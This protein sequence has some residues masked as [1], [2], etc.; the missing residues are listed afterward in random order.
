[1]QRFRKYY[2]LLKEF[3][4]HRFKRKLSEE[5]K[6]GMISWKGHHVEWFGSP[7]T[8]VVIHK[9][10]VKNRDGNTFYPEK[11]AHA[12]ELIKGADGMDKIEFLTSYGFPETIS[13]T[14]IIED[15]QYDNGKLTTGDDEIDQY[16]SNED[17]IGD[18]MLDESEF[19]EFVKTNQ[20]SMLA[21]KTSEQLTQ[22]FQTLGIWDEY[23]P[24]DLEYYFDLFIDLETRLKDAVDTNQG[25]I[26][27]HFVQLRD[28]HHRVQ[29][30]IA[31]G[32]EY[33]CVDIYKDSVE[34]SKGKYHFVK[35]Q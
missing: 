1:M 22:E 16:L 24:E 8:M 34:E 7:E 23:E 32:E 6:R 29:S 10:Q 17:Y 3:D 21:G 5:E 9:D 31:A 30:A 33:V 35:D 28:G 14:N 27:K 25:D 26:N 11:M 20:G 19:I 13:L 12:V 2:E 15:H 4:E 18:E